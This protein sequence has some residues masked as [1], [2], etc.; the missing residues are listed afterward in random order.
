MNPDDSSAPEFTAQV[1]E[2]MDVMDRPV[3]LVRLLRHLAGEV[4][5]RL[6]RMLLGTDPTHLKERF[7]GHAPS[8]ADRVE[9]TTLRRRMRRLAVDM[10]HPYVGAEHLL[11]ALVQHRDGAL[12]DLWEELDLRPNMVR[13]QV[14]R[15]LFPEV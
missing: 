15:S 3:N 6:L 12:L 14:E 2:W 9:L 13:A 1:E 10:D 8:S 11:I 7:A 4:H 5:P